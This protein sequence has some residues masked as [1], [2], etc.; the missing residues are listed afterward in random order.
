MKIFIFFLVIRHLYSWSV[1]H[2]LGKR[3]HCRDNMKWWV[4]DWN[5]LFI[6]LLLLVKF[7]GPHSKA[8]WIIYGPWAVSLPRASSYPHVIWPRGESQRKLSKWRLGGELT[9]R[10]YVWEMVRELEKLEQEF[11]KTGKERAH[12]RSLWARDQRQHALEPFPRYLDTVYST[13]R[14]MWSCGPM[15][16]RSWLVV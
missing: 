13:T 15:A 14:R 1:R 11:F 10:R 12:S 9:N 16:Q 5:F 6:Y 3:G 2:R 7:N 4:T 8:L